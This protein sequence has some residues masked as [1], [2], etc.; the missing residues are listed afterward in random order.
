MQIFGRHPWT[1]TDATFE[2]S[3]LSGVH[4]HCDELH[5]F[6]MM[7]GYTEM[8]GFQYFTLHPVQRL[9]SAITSPSPRILNLR[10]TKDFQTCVPS[11][12]E[13]VS[14]LL[15]DGYVTIYWWSLCEV[16]ITAIHCVRFQISWQLTGNG[17]S[18]QHRRHTD[19]RWP[20]R[21]LTL[22]DT[23]YCTILLV[24]G[25]WQYW[26]IMLI[27]QHLTCVALINILLPSPPQ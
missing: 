2:H 20:L 7:D 25:E 17:D 8:C 26:V 1:H 27:A 3:Y 21:I 5:Y 10:R 4:L 24:L 18:W 23:D 12:H 22:S 9:A 14:L 16:S 13:S 6:P 11:A 19:R 15:S